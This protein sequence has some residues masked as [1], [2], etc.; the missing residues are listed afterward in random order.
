M[1][2]Q[3]T[4]SSLPSIPFDG[5]PFTGK[6]GSDGVINP[7]EFSGWRKETLSW[8]ETAY[9]GAVISIPFFYQITG[10]GAIDFFKKH[11]V[12]SFEK[13]PVGR[14][15]HGIMCR[16]DGL[17]MSD[18]VV[19]RT[20]ED[21]FVTS[22]MLPYIQYAFEQGNY[23][24][25][26]ED[27]T[28]KVFLYQVG[29][30]R[31]LEI[32]ESATGEDLH[33]IGFARFRN[34]KIAG[35]DVRIFRLGMAGTLAY[36]VHGDMQDAQP[37][38]STIYN[39]GKQ[40]GIRKL[41]QLAY[42]MNH[43]EDGFPQANY[44]FGYPWYEDPYFASY[45]DA[46]PGKGFFNYRPNFVGS[47][48][49]DPKNN[50]RNPVELGWGGVIK[51]DHDFVGRTALEKLVA[52]P[53]RTT[54]TLEWNADDVGDVF[55]SQFRDEVPYDHMDRPND[56]YYDNSTYFDATYTWTY[57]ADKIIK[58]GKIIGISSGRARS[59]Y[60]H[61]MISLCTLDIEYA[62]IGTEVTVVW[63]NPGTPQRDIRATVA[64]FPYLDKDRNENV[65]VDT[66]P[67]INK[68]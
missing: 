61:R 1:N 65:D 22:W 16:D 64:R 51:F 20:A 29:G 5:E 21:K 40:F 39:A 26:G 38:Y 17:M 49:T 46:H 2:N 56:M 58:D 62:K 24:A 52:N 57:H 14:A 23:D 53:Q 30:P 31:S 4:F 35:K 19:L 48:G 9:L 18:G 42:M 44:H 67:R 36:E 15:K 25:V 54:V 8:K 28:G 55:A 3:C 41:G 50:F 32:L 11:F 68:K 6:V 60:F 45:L 37:V 10:P 12:N 33:D 34:S 7:F 47:M 59:E 43:T 63:G 27:I 66:I 13:F